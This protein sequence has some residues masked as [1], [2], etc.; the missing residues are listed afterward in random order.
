MNPAAI[1]AGQSKKDIVSD[2]QNAMRKREELN[3]EV[4]RERERFL[5]AHTQ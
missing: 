2:Q 4:N 3:L 1:S 5:Y